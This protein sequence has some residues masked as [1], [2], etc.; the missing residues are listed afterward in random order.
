MTN[1]FTIRVV[2]TADQDSVTRLLQA[3][4]PKLMQS[5]YSPEV[6][7]NI[8]PSITVA[9]SSL[10]TSGTFYVAQTPNQ[11]IIGCGGWTKEKPGSGEIKAGI[12]HIRHFA[13]HP[14]WLRKSV[15]TSI[16]QKCEQEAKISQIS[17]F[18]CYSSLNAQD[19][20]QALG[21]QFIKNIDVLLGNN[22]TMTCIL[23]KRFI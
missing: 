14:D 10:L 16:Y 4:Y 18:E 20:Y 2:S 23:M 11:Q 7:A 6:L 8:L 1:E 15:G 12:A 3:S 9:N 5:R 21:F 19:F 22:Q 17:N 13:T